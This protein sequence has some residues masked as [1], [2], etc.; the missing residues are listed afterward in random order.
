[1]PAPVV[2]QARGGTSSGGVPFVVMSPSEAVFRPHYFAAA[3]PDRPSEDV[4]SIS[5]ELGPALLLAGKAD[6]PST[7]ERALRAAAALNSVVEAAGVPA[8]RPRGSGQAA[9]GVALAGSPEPPRGRHG[10]G[11][12]RLFAGALG[13]GATRD[14]ARPWPSSGPPCS[15][16]T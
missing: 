7:A 14:A 15:R 5:T 10:R 3:A 13:P 12:G 1:M 9:P 11:R 8:G 4:V 6:A 2:V 16:T